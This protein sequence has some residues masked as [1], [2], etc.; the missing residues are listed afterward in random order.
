MIFIA[1]DHN[2]KVLDVVKAKSKELA[3]AYLQGKDMFPHVLKD[4]D[5]PEVYIPLDQHPT[6]VYSIVKVT[7]WTGSDLR[8]FIDRSRDR[9]REKFNLV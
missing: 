5:D 8:E 2:G 9:Y 7:Q 3:M 1:E 4:V 6:G